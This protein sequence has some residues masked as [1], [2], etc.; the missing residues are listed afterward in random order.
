MVIFYNLANLCETRRTNR[1]Y[2][3]W[4][5][6]GVSSFVG[7]EYHGVTVHA[8]T[9]VLVSCILLYIHNFYVSWYNNFLFN[10]ACL[11][12]PSSCNFSLYTDCHGNIFGSTIIL[13]PSSRFLQQK[14]KLTNENFSSLLPRPLLDWYKFWSLKCDKIIYIKP[15]PSRRPF[16]KRKFDIRKVFLHHNCKQYFPTV[17][18]ALNSSSQNITYGYVYGGYFST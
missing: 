6:D 18:N 12:L 5:V 17:C 7:S 16:S 11:L 15:P 3:R 8:T 10:I 4:F 1:L 2:Q 14:Q 13:Y 9:W